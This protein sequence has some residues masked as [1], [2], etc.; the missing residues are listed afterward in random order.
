MVFY[1][2][3]FIVLPS[4]VMQI[5][6]CHWFKED[7]KNQYWWNYLVHFL[8]LGTM[9][10]YMQAFWDGVSSLKGK[11]KSSDYYSMHTPAWRDVCLL[12]LFEGFLEAAPQ[13]ILQLYIL[14]IQNEFIAKRDWLTATSAVVSVISLAC[15]I[16]SYSQMLRLCRD[17][18][19]SSY[20]GQL[21]QVL[22]LLLMVASRV[23]AL[24]L[25]A[26]ALKYYIFVVFAGHSMI[27]LGWL[28]CMDTDSRSKNESHAELFLNKVFTLIISMIYFFCFLKVH[29]PTTKTEISL[30]YAFMFIETGILMVA[31]Y[32]YRTLDGTLV[33]AAFGLVFGGYIFGLVIML[34]YYKYFHPKNDIAP[35][36][37]YSHFQSPKSSSIN[38][39]TKIED[40]ADGDATKVEVPIGWATRVGKRNSFNRVW[41]ESGHLESKTELAS[42]QFVGLT[43]K[44]SDSNSKS[45]QD[46]LR[47]EASWKMESCNRGEKQG[48]KR[49]ENFET[50]FTIEAYFNG[51]SMPSNA[52]RDWPRSLDVRD[53]NQINIS[54]FID[55]EQETHELVKMKEQCVTPAPK[56]NDGISLLYFV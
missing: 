18:N 2:M 31:W 50:L 42:L 4:L 10:R 21:F 38:V 37:P 32:P 27:M 39:D 26:S 29:Q 34:L 35:Q 52:G 6:S 55:D 25:F 23:V 7:E 41:D 8:Q 19:V 16:A 56:G 45:K 9:Q 48:H 11:L 53:M 24:V 15:A 22:Y 51:M 17:R 33:Y 14:T 3:H 49:S 40:V 30:Y 13:M 28:C 36:R 54:N 20:I 12:R 44:K 5:F 1:D 46:S 47:M 43:G